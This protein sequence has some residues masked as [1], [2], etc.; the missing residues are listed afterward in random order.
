MDTIGNPFRIETV[1]HVSSGMKRIARS[2]GFATVARS[3]G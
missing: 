3:G 2:G 1:T